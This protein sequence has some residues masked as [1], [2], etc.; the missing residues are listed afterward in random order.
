MKK[1]L[2][3]CMLVSSSLG[4][5]PLIDEPWGP[6]SDP[7]LMSRFFVR[8]FTKLPLNGDAKTGTRFWSGSYWSTQKGSINLRWNSENRIGHNLDS[9]TKNEVIK[10]NL[11]QLNKLSPT[12]KFDLFRGRYDYPLVAEVAAIADPNAADWEGI[13][14]G[15]APASVNH[16]EPIP[17]TMFNP[18]GIQIPFGSSDI[19]ALISYYYANGFQVPDTH[20]MGRRCEHGRFI[21][22]DPDCQEDLNAGAFHIALTN[23]IGI[24][25]EGFVADMDRYTEVWNQ[26]LV[27]YTSTMTIDNLP[28]SYGSSPETAKEIKI[29]TWLSYVNEAPDSW[30]PIGDRRKKVFLSYLLELNSKNEIVGGNWMSKVR[31]DFMWLK[32]PP[33][34]FTGNLTGLGELLPKK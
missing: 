4:A 27:A 5:S 28:P 1:L 25:K 30:E 20:Q 8:N 11:N 19:K 23:K 3:I 10:L 34:F 32:A 33:A 7:N 21:N 22:R 15:W 12:E 2:I 9:P 17:R 6:L 18:D 31:P 14:H 16:P 13:C 29:E 24:M 26:P